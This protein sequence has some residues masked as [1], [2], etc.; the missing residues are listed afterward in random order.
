GRPVYTLAKDQS[1]RYSKLGEY[2]QWADLSFR[3][4]FK[5]YRIQYIFSIEVTNIFNS[6]NADIINNVTGNAYEY[7]DPTPLSWNDPLYPDRF[8]PISSP[9]PFNPARYREPRQ[10]RFGISLEF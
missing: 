1:L 2:W 6:Q 9:F 8:Y 4:F 10:I 5:I 7:G 3:K